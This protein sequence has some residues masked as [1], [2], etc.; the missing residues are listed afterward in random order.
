MNGIHTLWVKP[1]TGNFIC[2]CG[3]AFVAGERPYTCLC[4]RTYC[5]AWELVCAPPRV[6]DAAH[7]VKAVLEDNKPSVEIL[8][9]LTHE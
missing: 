1:P 4:G 9:R 5:M 7:M 8:D 3:N 6:G 2:P